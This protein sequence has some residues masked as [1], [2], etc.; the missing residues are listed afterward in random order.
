[1]FFSISNNPSINE[2]ESATSVGNLFTNKKGEGA[3]LLTW[4]VFDNHEDTLIWDTQAVPEN[5]IGGAA[6][7]WANDGFT[8]GEDARRLLDLPSEDSIN[9]PEDYV[10]NLEYNEYTSTFSWELNTT[11]IDTTTTETK[12]NYMGN[13]Q[14]V[15]GLSTAE[16][17][18]AIVIGEKT[19][20]LLAGDNAVD[21]YTS[22]RWF[23]EL[24]D[25]SEDDCGD[26]LRTLSVEVTNGNGVAS[27]E[28]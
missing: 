21:S 25:Q 1:M 22:S 27:F 17:E 20:R 6:T 7:S 2:I 11:I 3:S 28:R 14:W 8:T 9:D 15:P 4:I 16:A 19:Y 10:M 18:Q 23:F 5:D 24:C 12:V 13:H 26:A